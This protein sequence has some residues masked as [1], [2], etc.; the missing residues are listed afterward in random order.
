[1][2]TVFVS[3][4]DSLKVGER[5]AI[6]RHTG[7]CVDVHVVD[8]VVRRVCKESVLVS[9]NGQGPTSSYAF[10]GIQ[11]GYRGKCAWLKNTRLFHYVA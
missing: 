3:N 1:M 2:K 9:V 7:P 8:A 4:A 6:Q 5:V 11:K 10:P